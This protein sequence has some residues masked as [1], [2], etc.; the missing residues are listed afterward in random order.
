MTPDIAIADRERPQ[1]IRRAAGA[2]CYESF[3]PKSLSPR[4]RVAMFSGVMTTR[5]P[6]DFAPGRR[7]L[8]PCADRDAANIRPMS[9]SA[10][11]LLFRLPISAIR[12]PKSDL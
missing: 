3:T 8:R 7:S 9:F 2:V 11:N 6:S 12:T 5:K 1:S 10:R 4:H